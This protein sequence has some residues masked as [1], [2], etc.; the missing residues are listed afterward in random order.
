MSKR[1]RDEDV[2][3]NLDSIDQEFAAA[4]ANHTPRKRPKADEEP[5]SSGKEASGK[6]KAKAKAKA[7]GKPVKRSVVT[8][9]RGCRKKVEQAE[10]ALNWPGCQKCKRA[11]DNVT[12]MAARQGQ[13]QVEFVRKAR[14]CEDGCFNL[15]QSYLDVCPESTERRKGCSRGTWSIAKYMERVTAASG[16]VRDKCGEMQ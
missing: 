12:K 6:G 8:K 10:L 11:L 1:L 4:E 7:A 15:I 9:C 13:D 3:S 5:G 16:M 2:A 14:Q